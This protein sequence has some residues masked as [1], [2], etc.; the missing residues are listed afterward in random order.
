MK[1]ENIGAWEKKG[2]VYGSGMAESKREKQRSFWRRENKM[3][4]KRRNVGL[5][6]VINWDSHM[7]SVWI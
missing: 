3:G 5:V 4:D 6:T 2:A 7:N 1:R